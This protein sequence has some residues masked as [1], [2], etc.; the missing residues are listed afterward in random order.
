MIITS[1]HLFQPFEQKKLQCSFFPVTSLMWI[2][3]SCLLLLPAVEFYQSH[4]KGGSNQWKPSVSLTLLSDWHLF[5][6]FRLSLSALRGCI[7]HKFRKLSNH[8]VAA[9]KT[10]F[11]LH[12]SF[13]FIILRD[14]RTRQKLWSSLQ[15]FTSCFYLFLKLTSED[16]THNFGLII[17]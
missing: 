14:K 3:I 17:Y 6:C 2:Y 15:L 4:L 16:Q 8:F 10:F 12:V 9:F 13:P 7:T 1:Y 5:I 11:L